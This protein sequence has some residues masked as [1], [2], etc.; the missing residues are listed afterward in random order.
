MNVNHSKILSVPTNIITG[1]L[2]AGKST[3]ILHLLKQKP[4]H[5]RW[6]VLVNEF[7]EVGID[8]SLFTGTET[9]DSGVF[10]R[11]VSGGCAV[12]PD[13]PCK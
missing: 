6:A 7:G 13:Y 3:A 1:F 11:E 10:I 4:S 9:E 2:G 12:P 5:E 8:G